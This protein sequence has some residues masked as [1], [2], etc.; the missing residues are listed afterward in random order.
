MWSSHAQEGLDT[1]RNREVEARLGVFEVDSADLPDAVEPV[2][3][4]VGV[5]A[6]PLGRLL[7]LPCLEV[8]AQRGDQVAFARAVVLD[9]RPEM[10]AAVIDQ[11]LVGDRGEE[12]GEA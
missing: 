1:K 2:A 8:G 6:Q 10:P 7:L 5:N 12:A 3:E 11:S 4:R 9:E